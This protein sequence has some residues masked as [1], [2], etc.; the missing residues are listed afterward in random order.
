[1][2]FSATASFTASV[3]LAAIGALTLRQVRNRRVLPFALIPLIFALQQFVEGIT[4]LT[5]DRPDLADLQKITSLAFVLIVLVVWPLWIPWSTY[6]LEKKAVRKKVILSAGIV[7][8]LFSI[9]AIFYILYLDTETIFTCNHISYSLISNF[10]GSQESGLSDE[11]E[12]MGYLINILPK[13]PL[14]YFGS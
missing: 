5:N 12:L 4:W 9:V 7:G 14:R 3:V 13:M 10:S 1:M 8:C 11:K 2:C 6:L